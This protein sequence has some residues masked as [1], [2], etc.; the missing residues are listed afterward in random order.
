M[1]STLTRPA[2]PPAATMTVAQAVC[3]LELVHAPRDLDIDDAAALYDPRRDPR[4]AQAHA[5]LGALT[6]QAA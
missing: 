3:Y 6:A 4:Y 1:P 5:V 2:D